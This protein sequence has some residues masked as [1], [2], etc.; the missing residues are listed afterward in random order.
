V[1][2]G[3]IVDALSYDGSVRNA[4]TTGV[5]EHLTTTNFPPPIASIPLPA[6]NP[7]LTAPLLASKNL[8]MTYTTAVELFPSPGGILY[9]TA[10][11]QIS[12]A[13]GNVFANSLDN[14]LTYPV[15]LEAFVFSDEAGKKLVLDGANIGIENFDLPP[16]QSPLPG[17]YTI[18]GLGTQADPLHIQLGLTAAQVDDQNGFV[19][20]H[21]RFSEM[22]VPEPAGCAM[23]LLGVACLAGRT[24]RGRRR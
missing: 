16:F 9:D 10:I 24:A 5:E 23:L 14:T 20:L 3:L 7:P 1:S 21:L 22:I 6:T 2:A 15:Q 11:I 8:T 19:K 13:S 17:S 18:T 4:L 12:S